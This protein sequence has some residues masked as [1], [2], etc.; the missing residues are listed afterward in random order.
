VTDRI[1]AAADS[2]FARFGVAKTTMDDVARAAGVSRPTVY[3]HFATR[4]DLLVAVV[5]ERTRAQLD[6]AAA[7]IEPRD[8]VAE[9]VSDGLVHLVGDGLTDPVTRMLVDPQAVEGHDG[10]TDGFHRATELAAQLWRPVLER[11][12]GDGEV[13]PDLD[14]DELV[15]W[16]TVVSLI[17]TGRMARGDTDA[18]A[19][20]RTVE[21]FVVPALGRA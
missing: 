4:N 11:G 21:T 12:Q 14:L 13:D 1:V 8:S 20:R 19:H 9:K 2:C 6:R 15:T 7:L 10:L 17:L 18:E 5:A 3:R 16:F